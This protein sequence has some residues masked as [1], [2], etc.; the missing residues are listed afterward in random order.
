MK[1]TFNAK[2]FLLVFSII[3]VVSLIYTFVFQAPIFSFFSLNA[4]L[5]IE[6]LWVLAVGLIGLL[7]LILYLFRTK[8]R[9]KEISKD[10]NLETLLEGGVEEKRIHRELTDTEKSLLERFFRESGDKKF[11]LDRRASVFRIQGRITKAIKEARQGDFVELIPQVFVRGLK[12]TPENYPPLLA[13]EK[14]FENDDEVVAE[15]SPHSKHVWNLYKTEDL[16]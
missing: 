12:I 10:E 6:L 5:A 2:V 3:V 14:D 4:Q 7:S 8:S 9:L 15:F 11:D 1:L 13:I 16:K